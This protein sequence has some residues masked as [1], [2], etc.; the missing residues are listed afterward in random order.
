MGRLGLVGCYNLTRR[1]RHYS[2]LTRDQSLNYYLC[3]WATETAWHSTASQSGG[4]AANQTRPCQLRK[5]LQKFCLVRSDIWSYFIRWFTASPLPTPGF[6]VAVVGKLWPV[7][8]TSDVDTQCWHLV[9]DIYFFEC[10][11]CICI[12][13]HVFTRIVNILIVHYCRDERCNE[14]GGARKLHSSSWLLTLQGLV[15]GVAVTLPDISHNALQCHLMSAQVTIAHSPINSLIYILDISSTFN[16]QG[17]EH[18]NQ[19]LRDGPTTV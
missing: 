9:G 2:Q 18:Q 14:V 19:V 11:R 7:V 17:Y 3:H 4:D 13:H 6:P 15:S 1:S 5:W 10:L 8:L 16:C 12:I